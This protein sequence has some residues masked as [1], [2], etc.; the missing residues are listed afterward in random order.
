MTG[1]ANGDPVVTEAL[2]TRTFYIVPRVNPD[3]A[4]LALADKPT[5]PPQQHARV[6]RGCDG[7]RWPGLRE[8]DVDGDGRHS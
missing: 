4:E 3:G 5:L 8:H 2:R 7:H 6:G 1:H